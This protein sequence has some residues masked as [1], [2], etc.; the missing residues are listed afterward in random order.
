MDFAS[1]CTKALQNATAAHSVALKLNHGSNSWITWQAGERSNW[2]KHGSNGAPMGGNGKSKL[3][4]F[5]Q[6]FEVF[7]WKTM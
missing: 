1:R 2:D 7:V 6:C 5:L 4:V 3:F